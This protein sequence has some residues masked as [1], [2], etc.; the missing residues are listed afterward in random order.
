M[1]SPL[2]A[3]LCSCPVRG[4]NLSAL[5]RLYFPHTFRITKC[6]PEF[7]VF[8]AVTT[9]NAVFRDVAPYGSRKN[10]RF[11]RTCR[12]HLQNR[13]IRE[14]D[15]SAVTDQLRAAAA[16]YNFIGEVLRFDFSRYAA[17]LEFVI[18]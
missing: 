3:P 2:V 12:L 13:N 10:R 17:R 11:G 7:E 14:L 4:D 16:L 6:C 8:T 15:R 1:T 5:S 18:S 9:K